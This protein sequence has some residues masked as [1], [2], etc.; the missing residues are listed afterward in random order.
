M[1]NETGNALQRPATAPAVDKPL[2]AAARRKLQTWFQ[3]GTEKRKSH[4]H[5]YAHTMFAQCVARDP[6]NLVY[7]EALL[8]NLQT[9]YAANKRKCKVRGNRGTFKKAVAAEQSRDVIKAGLDL[10]KDNPWDVATLRGMA[11]A[12][13]ALHYNEV[14]LRYLKNALDADPKNVHVNRHC[15][16]SL[17]RMGQFDQAI[18]CWHRIEH[19]AKGEAQKNISDLTVQKTRH[20]AGG[21]DDEE[22]PPPVTPPAPPPHEHSLADDSVDTDSEHGDAQPAKIEHIEQAIVEQPAEVSNYL[23]LADQLVKKKEYGRAKQRCGALEA[24]GNNVKV[25]EK[26][27]K[28]QVRKAR[29]RLLIAEQRARQDGTAEAQQLSQ[30]LREELNR[31]ELDIYSSRSLRY[32]QDTAIRYELGVRLMRSGNFTQAAKYFQQSETNPQL[33]SA[34]WLLKGECLQQMR[35]Y[36]AAFEAYQIAVNAAAA[37]DRE[38]R[39]LALYRAGILAAAMKDVVH[40]REFFTQVLAIDPNFRDAAARLDKLP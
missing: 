27:E 15:A 22:A 14:E 34:A 5:D 16:Q 21:V 6:S 24:S 29:K 1:A 39:P 18:A 31:L 28:I 20:L 13:A 19:V 7:V 11:Q 30:Q 3:Y 35:Q 9:K 26:L 23:R 12:C 10:L 4:D 40:A 17:T 37:D 32:P 25:R 33:K 8:E 36:Q 2:S 38:V